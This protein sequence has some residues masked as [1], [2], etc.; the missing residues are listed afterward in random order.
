M[1]EMESSIVLF[2]ARKLK[3]KKDNTIQAASTA[4]KLNPIKI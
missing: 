3:E 4:A 2:S 1:T